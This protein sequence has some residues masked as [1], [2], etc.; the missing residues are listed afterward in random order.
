MPGSAFSRVD[1]RP[2]R[3]LC[4]ES[5]CVAIIYVH[6]FETYNN[7][8]VLIIHLRFKKYIDVHTKTEYKDVELNPIGAQKVF[9]TII[10]NILQ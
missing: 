3:N 7:K 4:G 5:L 9:W 2:I 1:V 8:H 6:V 10:L